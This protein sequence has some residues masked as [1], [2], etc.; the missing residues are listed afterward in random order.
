MGMHTSSKALTTGR[1][2]GEVSKSFVF[3]VM[4]QLH[5]YRYV[6]LNVLSDITTQAVRP[7]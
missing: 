3:S 4:S 7:I 6:E 5:L 2:G 1:L